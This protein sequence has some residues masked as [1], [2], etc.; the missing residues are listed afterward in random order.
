MCFRIIIWNS[1]FVLILKVKVSMYG[2]EFEV[3][4]FYSKCFFVKDIIC[5]IN[6]FI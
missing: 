2:V 5:R 4:D 3:L 1:C 6:V